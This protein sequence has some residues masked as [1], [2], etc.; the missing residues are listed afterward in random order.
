MIAHKLHDVDLW[1]MWIEF[2]QFDPNHFGVLYV[3][4]E[5]EIGGQHDTKLITK[6]EQE[7]DGQLILRVPAR[8][9]G[10]SRMKEVLYS[11]PVSN[12]SQYSSIFIYA[13]DELIACFHEIE[14][15]V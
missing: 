14:V 3:H 4:G 12:L 10:R 11:E 2:D 1:E 15:L 5:I 6:T 8:P 7:E 13:G 9:V